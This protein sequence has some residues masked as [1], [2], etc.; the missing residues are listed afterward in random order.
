[1]MAFYRRKMLPRPTDQITQ[2]AVLGAQVRLKE[3]REEQRAIEEF[4]AKFPNLKGKIRM[5]TDEEHA[6]AGTLDTH[7]IWVK[8]EVEKRRTRRK[9]TAKQK[10]EHRQRMKQVWA[11]RK[12]NGEKK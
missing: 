11:E 10:R 8:A 6:K 9:W 4:L 5:P 2:M 3:L 1:M 12:G 7:R